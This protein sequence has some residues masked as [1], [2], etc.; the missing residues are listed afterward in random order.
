M[1][2]SGRGGNNRRGFKHRERDKDNKKK[3][4]D[5]VRFDKAKGALVDRPKWTAP[6]ISA[7]PIPVPECPYCGK[8]I[9]DLAA[10]LTDKS[11]GQAVH[12]DCVV[13]R[14]AEKETLER[15]DTVT[16][17]GGGRFGVVH[18][19]NPQDPR[20]FTIKKIFEWEDKEHRADWRRSL[21]DHYS[22][23]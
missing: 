11:S 21:A 15:G 9:R 3:A 8:P 14:L 23:T 13:A 17:I 4:G 19:S 18:F 6:K 16:Y 12:F 1:S 2:G 7:E 10:A 5:N 22:I 20:N